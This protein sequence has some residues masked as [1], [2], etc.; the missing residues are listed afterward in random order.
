MSSSGAE[1]TALLSALKHPL[2]RDILREVR[3][4]P[5]ISPRQIATTLDETL[6]NVGYHC[7]VLRDCGA[8]TQVR[9]EPVRGAIQHFYRSDIDDPWVLAVLEQDGADSAI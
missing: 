6:S 4:C 9:Q 1:K 7:R 2:R 3:N 5:E 8:L